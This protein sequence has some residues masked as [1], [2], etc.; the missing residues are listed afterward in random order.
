MTSTVATAVTTSMAT[1]AFADRRA[2]QQG[3]QSNDHNSDGPFGHG[4]SL[5][6]THAAAL[7]RRPKEAKVPL[8]PPH[9]TQAE[10]HAGTA[11]A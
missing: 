4:T 6:A 1:A 7:E 2:R 5:R 11:M 9:P 8:A 3:R 10:Q